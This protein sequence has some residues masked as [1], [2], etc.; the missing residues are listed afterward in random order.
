[1][2]EPITKR[3]RDEVVGLLERWL[4]TKQL[5]YAVT[6]YRLTPG[7]HAIGLNVSGLLEI[8]N[9]RLIVRAKRGFIHVPSLDYAASIRFERGSDGIQ[10]EIQFVAGPILI[11]SDHAFVYLPV[12]YA[13]G[14]RRSSCAAATRHA[15]ALL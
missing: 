2:A 6:G 3:Q 13:P 15:S 9:Q 7:A 14:R 4:A 1:M 8:V 12:E 5:V 11:L 10:A